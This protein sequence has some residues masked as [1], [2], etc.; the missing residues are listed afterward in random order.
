MSKGLHDLSFNW[1]LLFSYLKVKKVVKL[2]VYHRTVL[3]PI[4]APHQGHSVTLR[5]NCRHSSEKTERPMQHVIF[6]GAGIRLNVDGE[7]GEAVVL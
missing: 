6:D 2:I 1:V 7:G 4:S 5:D 3:V